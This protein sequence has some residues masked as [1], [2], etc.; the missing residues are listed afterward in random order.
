MH[1]TTKI[2]R[3][4]KRSGESVQV[5]RMFR[6]EVASLVSQILLVLAIEKTEPHPCRQD[7]GRFFTDA[8]ETRYEEWV[9]RSP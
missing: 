9:A 7:R 8:K 5:A 2:F 6:G 4:K 1:K 3:K